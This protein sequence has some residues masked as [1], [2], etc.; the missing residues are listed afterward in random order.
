MFFSVTKLPIVLKGILRPDDAEL[1]VHHG[2]AAIA[3]SNHGA[4]QLDGVL[5]TVFKSTFNITISHC[6]IPH[7]NLMELIVMMV[8]IRSMRYRP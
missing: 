3:V 4:R 1:A 2:A 7:S 6:Y 5:A 8:F